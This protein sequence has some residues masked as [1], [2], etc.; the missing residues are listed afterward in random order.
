MQ[1]RRSTLFVNVTVLPEFIIVRSNLHQPQLE[2][3]LHLAASFGLNL[4]V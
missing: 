3:M 4:S 2:A 1:F